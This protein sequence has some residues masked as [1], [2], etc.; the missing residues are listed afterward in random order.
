MS[1]KRYIWTLVLLCVNAWLLSAQVRVTAEAA[2]DRD[3]PL[4]ARG[5]V[6]TVCIAPS[7][8]EV[9]GVVADLFADDVK[10]VSGRKA[11]VSRR[12]KVQGKAVIVVGTLG[13]NSLIDRWASRGTL[14]VSAIRDGWEQY[15]IQTLDNPE[16]GIGQALVIAG[17]D[18]RGTAYGLLSVSE[19]IGVSPFYWWADVPVPQRKSLY[20]SSLRYASKRPSVKYRGIFINDEGWGFRPWAAETFEPEVG[21]AGPRTYAKVC[22]LIL[23]LKGNMLAPAM[24]PKTVAFHRIP[25]NR[26]VADRYAIVMTSSHCEPLLYNNTTEWDKKLNGPWNY[27]E[28][29]EGINAVLDKRV[30]ETAAYENAYVLAL[31][32]IHDGGM[33][34]VPADRK[35]AVTGQ[36]LQ[37]QRNLLKKHIDK[38]IEEIPQ[39]FVPYKE[40]LDI[41]EQGLDLPDDVILVWPDD[42][43]GYIKRLSNAKEQKRKGGSGVYYHISYLGEPHDYLWLN[44]T[45]PTL[46]YEE[47]KKAYDTGADRYW[48]LN[49]GD[50]KPGELGMKF[51]LDMAW[52]VSSMSIDKAY[53]YTAD[54]LSG[55]FGRKYT[56]DLQDIISTYY[57]LGFQRKP[58]AM[59]WGPEWNHSNG[60]AQLLNTDFSF[61]NYNEAE[62]R[63]AEYDRITAKSEALMNALP[64]A[65]KAAFFEMVFYPV[66]G[67]CLMNKKMLT[68]QQN[69][70]YAVQGRASTQHFADLAHSYHDSIQ[71]YTRQFNEMLGGKWNKMM[72]LAPGWTA[73]YLKM[74]PIDSVQVATG[75][76][77]S[78]FLPGQDVEY[79][80]GGI[81]LL[82]CLNPYTRQQTFIEL[83]NKGNMAFRWT[84]TTSAPWIKLSKSSGNTLLQERIVVEV[85]WKQAP[86]GER[87]TG[88]I[89]LTSDG[90]TETVYL[91]LF[92]PSSP[93]VSE[94]AGWYVED[95]GCISIPA[96]RFHRKHEN[97][98]IR[99]RPVM[100]LGYEPEALQLGEATKPSQ[101][102]GR[103]GQV[104]KA[105]YDF[106][107][108]SAGAVT[109]H[110]YALPLFAIDSK[111]DSRYGIMIDDGVVYWM[112]TASKEYSSQWSQNVARNS[113]VSTVRLNVKHPGRHTLKLLCGDPGMIIQKVVIDFGGMKRSYLGPEPTQVSMNQ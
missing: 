12:T 84:A 33:V 83:Y 10:R 98:D 38:P 107:S 5:R 112:T 85:D 99:I 97:S 111:R 28:N 58:E 43:Y 35:V 77:M 74:P 37:D 100:G 106:Y 30:S 17:C 70:W 51:F 56:A 29:K 86:K 19:A 78:I 76:R 7:D 4:V 52:D 9:V 82:P 39:V 41:Y 14:D 36:A 13:R 11:K 22:E 104:P 81:N 26:V 53:A 34:G 50:I 40:V 94:L 45:P 16:E 57:L 92:N 96:G 18:R 2:S 73:T 31:R 89:L 46:I 25:E 90:K 79:A 113:A 105:E 27:L 61:V 64:D 48:L 44:T 88:E 101:R 1:K 65:Y 110:I 91:P 109:V 71:L 62:N 54:Y 93:S 49:V 21:N 108:F 80:T 103:I 67:A 102:S 20:I 32:G 8:Y 75:C 47:M 23:R 59:G 6:A 15:V 24:H 60:V 68:A 95:N 42:N 63:M 3:F 72:S 66:K 87:T 69:R 55:I